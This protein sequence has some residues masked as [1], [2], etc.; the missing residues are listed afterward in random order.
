MHQDT[1]KMESFPL[2]VWDCV[3]RREADI[4]SKY[5]INSIFMMTTALSVRWGWL[6]KTTD[7]S[8]QLYEICT[9][10]HLTY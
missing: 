3:G 5:P 10:S 7:L 2:S 4:Y 9:A 1:R 8:S 6:I